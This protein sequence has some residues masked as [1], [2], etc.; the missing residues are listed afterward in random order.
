MRNKIIKE[1]RC[2]S[3]DT[4]SNTTYFKLSIAITLGKEISCRNNSILLESLS[5]LVLEN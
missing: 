1:G 2:L 3:I 5:S 4:I